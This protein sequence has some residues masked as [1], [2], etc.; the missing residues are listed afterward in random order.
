MLSSQTKLNEFNP[1]ILNPPSSIKLQ[2]H[3]ARRL[4]G[5]RVKKHGSEKSFM[6]R[7]HISFN[8][9]EAVAFRSSKEMEGVYC[10]FVKTQIKKPVIIA[11][12]VMPEL[13]KLLLEEKLSKWLDRFKP[14]TV[15]LCAFGS[16]CKLEKGQFQELLLGFEMTGLPFFTTLKPPNEAD[17]AESALPEGFAEK[18]HGKGQIFGGWVEQ[19]LVLRHPSIGCFVT[20][21]GLGSLFEAMINECQIVLMPHAGDQ[22]FNARIMSGDLKVGVEV[23]K[24]DED[25]LFTKEGVCKAVKD[26]MEEHS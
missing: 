15:I 13:P 7:L 14:K 8:A 26:V 5:V 23:E 25:R 17:I 19:Q 4:A 11:G 10:D 1:S 20:H 16:E 24:G 9:C 3:E 6:E 2:S 12:P 18:N 22:F 21:C